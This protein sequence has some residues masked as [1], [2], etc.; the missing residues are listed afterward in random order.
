M[1]IPIYQVDAFSSRLFG[2]NPAA[3]CP[4]EHWLPYETMQSIAAENNLAETAF[5]VQDGRGYDLRWFT[6]TTEI[7]LCGHATLAS[8]YVV[9][10]HLSP[11]V[12]TVSFETR[13]GEL[14][15]R[16]EE[17]L[18]S[19]DFPSRPPQHCDVHPRLIEALGT[20]PLDVQ[21]ARDYM[22]VFE[23]EEHVRTLQPNMELIAGLD[24]FA[25]IVTAPGAGDADF[26][27]RF[28]APAHGVPEDPVT[29]SAHCTLIPYWSRRLGK[30]RLFARQIS[31]REGEL[32]CEDR[33][34]RVTISGKAALYLEGRIRI[35]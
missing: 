6:P 16:R 24:R 28:F 26:V 21:A 18:Y 27:S 23:S 33:G 4:L 14:V 5:F 19:M 10:N 11:G 15:V 29:G 25:V 17:D 2:G 8:A 35:A 30:K 13:S 3:V 31:K 32:W 20:A 7:D 9:M 1:Q 22:V 34:D 12:S